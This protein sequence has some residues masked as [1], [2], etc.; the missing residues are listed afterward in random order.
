MN[1]YNYEK[2]PVYALASSVHTPLTI[3]T[4]LGHYVSIHEAALYNYGSMTIKL[5]SNNRLQS[6]ITPLSDG[7]RAYI[8]LP[9]D[10]PWRVIMIGDAP[11]ELVTNRMVLNLNEPPK[12]DFSWV[13][14]LKFLG[15][16]WAMFVG[17]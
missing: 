9:F 5:N 7:M 1:E 11:I 13:K 6:D 15:I 16:W 3:E 2:R 8:D 10:T 14:P 12:Q 4:P 17:E